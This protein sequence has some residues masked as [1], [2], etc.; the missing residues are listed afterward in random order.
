MKKSIFK[1]IYAL[2]VFFTALFL[3]DHFMNI[4]NTDITMEMP[5]ATLPLVYIVQQ[6]REINGLH[7]YTNRMETAYQNETVTVLDSADRQLELRVKAFG[8]YINT[9]RFEVRSVD[10]ERLIEDT[11]ITDVE[12][13]GDTAQIKMV[14]K[15]LLEQD[16]EYSL[17]LILQDA[18]GRELYYYTRV[19]LSTIADQLQD[20]I[21]FALDFSSRTFDKERAREITKYLESNAEGDNTTYSNVTIHSS[22]AQITWGTLDVKK[23]TE[24]EIYVR[25]S[26]PFVAGIELRYMVSMSTGMDTEYYNVTEYYLIRYGKER[27]YLLDYERTMNSVFVHDNAIFTNNK[28]SLGI[29]D[30]GIAM[31]ESEDGN[32]LAFVKEGRLYS[33]NLTDNKLALLFG[34]YDA[35]HA[36]ARTLYDNA[37]IRIISVDETGNIRFLV[38]G[39]MN[40]GNHEGSVGACCYYYNSML[41]TI[42]EE[43][44]IPYMGSAGLLAQDVGRLVY[45]N[46]NNQLFMILYGCIYKIDLMRKSYEVLVEG[47]EESSYRVSE[48]GR[49]L[50]WQEGDNSAACKKLVLMNLNSGRMTEIEAGSGRYIRPLGFM[51]EDLIY[52]VAYGSDV[53]KDS[54]GMTV[55]PMYQVRIQDERGNVLKNYQKQGVYV[56]EIR[57]EG[58]QIN[59]KRVRAAGD[60]GGYVQASDDQIMNDAAQSGDKNQ[61]E[62]V[63]T[64]DYEKIVQIAVKGNYKFNNLK[65][66]TP[67]QVMYE[68][69][70]SLII[71]RQKT[72]ETYYY[73][74]DKYGVCAVLS[75]AN[76]AVLLADERMGYVQNEAGRYIWE[77]G[78]RIPVN[79]IMWFSEETMQSQQASLV[80]CL[81]NMLKFEGVSRNCESLLQRGKSIVSILQ[82]NLEGAQTLDLSGCSLGSVLYYVGKEAPVLA[83]LNDGNAVLIVGYNELNTVIY[84]PVSGTVSKMGM[85][86]SRDYFEANANQFITYKKNG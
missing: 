50:V 12:R 32:I 85:N 25:R 11:E 58:N 82:E 17:C 15:D 59:L 23:E 75:Q 71:S 70:R 27:M 6:G 63:A 1:C 51:N 39:Y 35:E 37:D 74:Y 76:E 53:S 45:V 49:M 4:G 72:E 57:V 84:N 80:V 9:A 34:F 66:L 8:G 7:G 73:V 67:K 43:I 64:Q 60:T 30:S 79:Q 18:G 61:I 20:E 81:N 13:D 54:L 86:D 2:L 55:F 36:D 46:N 24:P 48:S 28:I 22:F 40:R 3:I 56:T 68:G 42:E 5:D 77:K 29:T 44:Y 31:V 38:Y 47:L 26:N 83:L 33:V 65:Y 41:N 52:G 69:E 10:G 78:S 14:L 19:V 21:A 62:V 16:E